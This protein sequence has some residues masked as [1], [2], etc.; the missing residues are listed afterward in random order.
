M[1]AGANC[2]RGVSTLA[3]LAPGLAALN[4]GYLLDLE[5]AA[6]QLAVATKPLSPSAK[7]GTVAS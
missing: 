6:W 1:R 2:G 4:V 5:M 7:S 3:P